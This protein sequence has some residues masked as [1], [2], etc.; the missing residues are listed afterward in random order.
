MEHHWNNIEEDYIMASNKIT[1]NYPKGKKGYTMNFRHPIVKDKDGKYG[2]KVH[3]GLGT[4]NEGD[5]NILVAELENMINQE[6]WWNLSKR[7]EAYNH[8]NSIVVDAFYDPMGS[9]NS[10]E[11]SLLDK[12]RLPGKE[13]GFTR[14][15]MIGPSGVGKTTLLRLLA[16]TVDEKFP[17]T[18]TGRTTTCNMEMIMSDEGEYEV[19][20]TFMS[21]YVIEMYVQECI[22]AALEYCINCNLTS[23]D[24]AV[25]SDKL[26]IH[27]DLIVR[28]SYLL[29]DLTLTPTTSNPTD[30]DFDDTDENIDQSEESGYEFKQDV[31]K[32]LERANYFIDEIIN[33]ASIKKEEN[34]TLDDK[35]NPEE[36]TKVLSLR[37]E[38]V[39]EIMLRFDLLTQGER[40]DSKGKWVNAW[41]F[42]TTER[43]EFIKMIKMFSS[44]AKRAWGGLLTPIVKT[45]RVKGNFAP[46][47]MEKS[48][49]IVLFDGQGLGHKTTATSMPNE[50]VEHFKLSDSI[51]IVDN[52]QAPMLDNVKLA[53]KTVIEYGYSEKVVF[54]FTHVDLMKGDNFNKFDDKRRHIMAALNSYLFEMQR[55]N[56]DIFTDTEAEKITNSCYFF[57]DLDKP[58]PSKMTR[59]YTNDMLGRLKDLFT[60]GI[61]VD[62]VILKYDAM[63]LYTHLTIAIKKFRNNWSQVIGYP[64][65]S[66]NTKHWSRIKAL[67]RRLAYFGIDHYNYELMPLADFASEV[68]TQLN[69][70]MN[71]P[72]RVIP[73][74]T[75]E[76]VKVSLIN[77]LKSQINA[78]LIEFIKKQMWKDSSQTK[79]WQEAYG[80]S[81]RY[82]TYFR[83][84]K[85]NDIF[86]LAA[87]QIDNFAYN[88]TDIQKGYVME[89]IGIVE[90]TLKGHNCKLEKFNY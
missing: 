12:I 79:R 24:R 62:E 41:Y 89:V 45:M 11:S 65:K 3:R 22:E 55:Q 18:S 50:I 27:R 43:R 47:F 17:T 67:S 76:E 63:T 40:L 53:L 66:Q 54:A 74:E 64:S 75:V 33:I 28:F 42:K 10:D 4:D 69:V 19:I 37:D 52:A 20:I 78:E 16:G 32:L 38:I 85:V 80:F 30:D 26:F 70:F 84:S 46:S 31:N 58:E 34:V 82:S 39:N 29:G 14:T 35:Y 86:E 23:Y 68:R 73:E 77:E 88:M 61:T 36:D 49:N 7:N 59:K 81:G 87:P 57:S 72:L 60:M 13:D 1:C 71:R 44:N 83:A 51:I 2:L 9:V 21:R 5:A 15:T 48:P 25:I 56:E 6:Y 90:N 8:F